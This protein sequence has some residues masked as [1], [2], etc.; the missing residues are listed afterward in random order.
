M[1][2]YDKMIL[3]KKIA[4]CTNNFG[5]HVTIHKSYFNRLITRIEIRK[6]NDA[7]GFV[8]FRVVNRKINGCMRAIVWIEELW[9]SKKER[10]RGNA[11]LLFKYM[12]STLWENS[13]RKNSNPY[14]GIMGELTHRDKLNGNWEISLPFYNNLHL[15]ELHQNYQL[16]HCVFIGNENKYYTIDEFVSKCDSGEFYYHLEIKNN[17]D[18]EN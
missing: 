18:T 17:S 8:S 2:E 10:R 6:N 13:I 14:Y 12:I 15:K 1:S 3:S 16:G 4:N 9:V 11:I 7:V 5:E